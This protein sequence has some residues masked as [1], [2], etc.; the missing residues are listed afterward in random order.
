MAS[1][2]TETAAVILPGSTI[3]VTGA[4]GYIGCR[5]SNTLIERGYRVRGVVRDKER[6]QHIQDFFD[7]K[8]GTEGQFELFEIP[9][10]TKQGAFNDAV[11]GCAGL[12]HLAVDNGFSPDPTVVVDGSVALTLR[13]LEA[14]AS[15]PGLRRFV[16]TSSYI[17]ACQYRM[18]E[19]YEVTQASWNDNYV[20]KAWAPPPYTG[21]RSLYVYGA[22]K[23]QC[24]RAMWRFVEERAPSFVANAV[25]PDFVTGPSMP[26]DKPN[27]GPMSFA[28]EALWDGGEAWKFL[29]P[30]WMIDAEDASLLHLGALLHPGYQGER[31]FGCAHR[32]SWGD[33]I[34]RLRDMYPQHSFPEPPEKEDENLEII[35][36][37]PRA[38]ELLRWLGRV[39][40]RPMQD[41]IKDAFDAVAQRGSKRDDA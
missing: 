41:S 36:D 33:W 28:L 24:E 2:T 30:Q 10:L 34:R 25:L 29:G 40:F 5:L 13:A 21:D 16:L 11:K 3:L 32:K 22:A 19:A 8:Y 12:V 14:A 35:V 1:S 23:V 27:V 17:T 4:N 39:G 20:E 9:D 37:R 26:H 31:I 38:E 7:Q 18:N 15:E 6:C